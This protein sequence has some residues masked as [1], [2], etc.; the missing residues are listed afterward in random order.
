MFCFVKHCNVFCVSFEWMMMMM[1][2]IKWKDHSLKLNLFVFHS[3]L[4]FLFIH[5]STLWSSID[6]NNKYA[7]KTKQKLDLCK[8]FSFASFDQ[9]ENL[10]ISFFFLCH[11]QT[12]KKPVLFGF[13]LSLMSKM[14]RKN[15][16]PQTKWSNVCLAK[17]VSF[18]RIVL[19]R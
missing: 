11:L 1:I 13:Y 16:Q 14:E 3:I 19:C 17:R 8:F 10:L 5:F 6:N 18:N 9:K 7:N 4:F 15:N 12:Y 2:M